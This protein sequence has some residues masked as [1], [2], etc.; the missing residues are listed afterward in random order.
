[1]SRDAVLPRRLAPLD[2]S[3]DS[4]NLATALLAALATL[5]ALMGSFEQIVS[6]FFCAALGFVA[7]A[8]AGLFVLRKRPGAG[9]A[10]AFRCPG[11][12][13]VPASFVLLIAAVV[14]TVAVAR[15]LQAFSGLGIVL[16][17]VPAYRVLKSRGALIRRLPQGAES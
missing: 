11:Y 6:F 10:T 3:R 8:V 14:A 2:P 9:R 13:L 16:L 4:S 15:P 1:M 5:Y 7:L 17:G 12:P